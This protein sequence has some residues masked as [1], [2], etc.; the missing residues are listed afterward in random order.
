MQS[1]FP[2]SLTQLG[3]MGKRVA[4]QITKITDGEIEMAFQ[5]PG[6]IVPAFEAFDA[7]GTG[8]VEAGWSNP[9]YWAGRVP[10]LQLLAAVPFGPQAGEYL[11]WMKFG[12]GQEFLTELYER[13][14]IKSL[15][16]AVT[17]PEAAGWFREPIKQ[18]RRPARLDHAFLRPGREGHGK[19]WACPL[20][21]WPVVTSSRRW[22]WAPSMRQSSLCLP[23]TSALAS[24]RSPA[25]ITSQVGTSSQ[26]SMTFSST[27]ICGEGLDES[28]QFKIETVCDAN[29][30]Y[31]L[32]EGE[33]L[34]FSA[35]QELVDNGVSLNTLSDDLLTALEA[36]WK[37]VVAEE[38]AADPGFRPCLMKATHSSA[39]IT[40]SG[41][42]WAS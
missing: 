15:P 2:G 25:S 31:G 38:S 35:L 20:S 7:V 37:E 39:K 14:N 26:P 19:R 21:F 36:A 28:T 34:Q 17:A 23:W 18:P 40:R 24:I 13:H 12:G 10:A 41:V 33:Y 6:A 30:A 8:A 1:T 16:C 9:G 4:E 27:L 32:A 5:E 29:L 42:T 22:N 3:T 11:A